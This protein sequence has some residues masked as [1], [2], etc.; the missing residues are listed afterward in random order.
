MDLGDDDPPARS[1]QKMRDG[2]V[3]VWLLRAPEEA[4]DGR[5]AR[6]LALLDA[7]ERAR[8]GRFRR[9]ADA[10]RYLF[11]HA[12]ARTTLSQYAPDVPPERWRF[13][14]G[15][16]GRPEVADATAALRF[17]ITHTAGLVACVVTH[18]RDVGVDVEHLYPPRWGDEACLEIAAAYFAPAEVAA[19]AAA[20]PD[21]RR[22]L[23]FEIWTLKEAYAKARGLGLALPLASYS[24]DQRSPEVRIRCALDVDHDPDGWRFERS[25][26][27][28]RHALAVAA[29]CAPGE[30]MA[31]R[32]CEAE[33]DS[34]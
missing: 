2:D 23:F 21:Q 19:L 8:I 34:P 33:A 4:D 6:A 25:R 1:T 26:P 10:R 31:V 32:I 20:P 29:R 9:R 22:G 11:A 7:D 15:A 12:L 14:I 18:G 13:R 24:F 30:A 3:H 5:A 28:P 16:H 27:T 17:N